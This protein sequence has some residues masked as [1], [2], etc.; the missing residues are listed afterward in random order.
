VVEN[1]AMTGA[2][3]RLHSDSLGL[4]LPSE[5]ILFVSLVMARGLPQLEVEDVG[6]KD[7]LVSTHSVLFLNHANELLVNLHAVR[8]EEGR[9][10]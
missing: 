1:K 8:V 10:G 4:N 9:S 6:G 3:H 2:V 5:N 7:L